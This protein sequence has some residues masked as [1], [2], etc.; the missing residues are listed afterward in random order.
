[1]TQPNTSRE[2]HRSHQYLGVARGC[3]FVAGYQSGRVE[4][5]H[6]GRGQAHGQPPTGVSCRH[7]VVALPRTHSGPQIHAGAQHQRL[8]KR[9]LGQR[10]QRR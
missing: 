7:R 10:L 2:T 9:L 8:T 4:D 1:M 6:G 3:P 5:F